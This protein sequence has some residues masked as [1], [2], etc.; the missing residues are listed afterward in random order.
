MY[1]VE[2]SFI[3]PESEYETILEFINMG[4][5][6]IIPQWEEWLKIQN[7]MQLQCKID[8]HLNILSQSK[9]SDSIV[10]KICNILNICVQD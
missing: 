10:E 5:Y 1:I 2:T 4:N 8:I 6:K 9:L 3:I 7:E